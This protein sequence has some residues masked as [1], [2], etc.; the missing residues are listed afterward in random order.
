MRASG[1]LLPIFSLPSDYGIGTLGEQAFR[2][3][4]FLA[5]AGQSC[6]QILPLGP[7]SFGDSPYQSFSVFAGNPYF[8]DLMLLEQDGLLLPEEYQNVDFG[9]SSVYIDYSKLFLNRFAV[10]R[11]AFERGFARDKKAVSAFLKKSA[12]LSDYALFMALKFKFEQKEWSLWDEDIRTRTP[13]AIK[14]YK[15]ELADDINFWVYTQFLFFRQWESLKKYAN[16]RGVK[17]IGDIPIYVAQDSADTWVTPQIFLLDEGGVPC[18]VAGVP[19]DGFS[20]TGQLWGN[21]LYDWEALKARDYDWW[22][23]RVRAVLKLYDIVRIDHFRGFDSYYAI[24]SGDK[25]AENGEWRKGPGMELFRVLRRELSEMNIIAEDLGFLTSSVRRL[26]K[27]SGYPGMKVLQFAFDSRE[28]SDYLPHNYQKNCVVYTG[29]HD[30]DTVCG[31]FKTAPPEDVRFCR[32]YLRLSE[33]EGLHW[34]FIKGAW[35]SVA[36]LSIAGMQDFLGLGSGSRINIP[37]T[38]G[39]NWRWRMQKRAIN[40]PLAARILQMTKTYGRF[41]APPTKKRSK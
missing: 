17:F 20:A 38:L 11:C 16:S 15:S 40:A 27:S 33:K 36:E 35:S 21:P 37:S 31:W 7:T 22:V 39:G 41:A 9:D 1:I 13:Q 30:N 26:L 12:W 4:D 25:T 18:E 23:E 3:V 28:E 29:T 19:P 6:W 14:K 32:R 10:L 24:P 8:I 2:F 5:A 34:G